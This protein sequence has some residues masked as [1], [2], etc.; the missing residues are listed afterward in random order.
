MPRP[1]ILMSDFSLRADSPPDRVTP[2][3]RVQVG[4]L[5]VGWVRGKAQALA[6]GGPGFMS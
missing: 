6:P 4:F 5:S 1:F 2:W 3:D